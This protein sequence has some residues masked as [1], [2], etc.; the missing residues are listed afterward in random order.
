MARGC[1]AKEGRG[2][3]GGAGG[4]KSGEGAAEDFYRVIIQILAWCFPFNNNNRRM[5]VNYRPL[6]ALP[7]GLPVSLPP[8]EASY[9]ELPSDSDRFAS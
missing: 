3:C 4:G 2:D 7:L 6:A 9:P 8:S 1:E 5:A